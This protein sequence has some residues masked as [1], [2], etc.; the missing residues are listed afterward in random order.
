MEISVKQQLTGSFHTLAHLQHVSTL[1]VQQKIFGPCFFSPLSI[2]TPSR[3]E[4]PLFFN[5]Y[6]MDKDD[7]VCK[8]VY[9]RFLSM[10][11]ST[12]AADPSS[13]ELKLMAVYQVLILSF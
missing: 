6:Y 3:A 2:G 4:D 9:I 13:Q 11:E 12:I 10:L 8:E 5:L 1:A 7:I